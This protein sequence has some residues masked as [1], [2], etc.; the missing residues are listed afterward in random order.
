M[1]PVSGS[2][3][4]AAP[5]ASRWLRLGREERRQPHPSAEI[6]VMQRS[7]GRTG[8]EEPF[9]SFLGEARQVPLGN[10]DN[11]VRNRHDPPAGPRLGRAEG[12]AAATHDNELAGNPYS[13]RGQ[14]DIA[15]PQAA[16]L[17]P[18]QAGEHRQQHK[19]AVSLAYCLAERVDLGDRQSR[20]PP[21][22]GSYRV[23][24]PNRL[25]VAGLQEEGMP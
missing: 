24:A 12:E 2:V 13:G 21:G 7:S 5:V 20:R 19:R 1:K 8:E 9:V 17:A 3:P 15:P 6:A 11:G 14:V 10:R 4:V 25:I 16:Q 18:S 23:K 22:V